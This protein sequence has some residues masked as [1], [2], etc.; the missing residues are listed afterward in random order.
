VVM[1]G[2][3]VGTTTRSRRADLLGARRGSVGRL[4]GWVALL[5]PSDGLLVHHPWK[6]RPRGL[7]RGGGTRG[8][9]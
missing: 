2:E 1:G 8:K 3:C 9:P 7:C 6:P 4:V 5:G